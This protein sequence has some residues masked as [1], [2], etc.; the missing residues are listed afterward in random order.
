M[1]ILNLQDMIVADNVLC[2]LVRPPSL[3]VL[4]KPNQLA[5]L[6]SQLLNSLSRLYKV[7]GYGCL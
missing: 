1:R 6:P 3:A 4:Y 7:H 2:E 5:S